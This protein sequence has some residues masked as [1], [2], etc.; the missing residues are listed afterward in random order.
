MASN[1]TRLGVGAYAIGVFVLLLGGNAVRNLVGLPGFFVIAAIVLAIGFVV[2]VKLRPERF[3]WYRLPTP[4]YVFLALAVLSIAWSAYRFESLL[5][6][7]AQLATTAAAVILA[8]MLSWQELLRTLAS[9]LRYLIGLS[10]IFELWVSWFA[11]RPLMPW[12]LEQPQDDTLLLLFWSRNVLFEGGPIQGIV[13]SSVILGFLA[14]IA[15]IVWGVQLRAG[16]VRPIFGWFWVLVAV[17]TLALT[18]SAT[19]TVA[20]AVVAVALLLAMWCRRRPAESRWPVYAVAAALVAA[21]VAVAVF[22]RDFVFGLLGKSS[23]LTGRAETWDAVWQ[24]IVERPVF[25]WGWVSYWPVWVEPFDGLDTQAGLPVPSAHNAWI[26]VWFQLGIV[27]LVIFSVFVLLTTGRAWFRAVDAPRRG[28]G[29]PLPHATSALWPWLVIVALLVQSITES[30]M[31]IEGGWLLLVVLSAKTRF[32][33]Q[34]P[35]RDTEPTKMAWR[36][37]PLRRDLVQRAPSGDT[38]RGAQ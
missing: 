12:W 10:L 20:L 34:L 4:L 32:D 17:A 31:L 5:G 7:A 1:K 29:P 11:Q 16:L 6:V 22:A 25:G 37:V 28:P 33:Y 21:G 3:R 26:D 23:D 9:S 13:A 35:S 30:R 36:D 38:S 15:L 2:F 19:V 18:R 27:G 24:H 14:L 8:Y